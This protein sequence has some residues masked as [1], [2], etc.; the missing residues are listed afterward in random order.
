MP[1]MTREKTELGAVGKFMERNF[2]HYNSRETV[3]AARAYKSHIEGKGK[4]FMAIAGAMS[5]GELGI[6]LAKM[7]REGKIHAISS[8]AANL[9][10][11]LFN[12]MAHDD[13][14]SVPNYRDLTPEQEVALR[15]K[16]F[17]RVTDVCIP[18]DAMRNLE[19]HLV[20]GVLKRAAEK[21]E[22]LFPWE[23]FYRLLDEGE[24][25]KY[26][27]SSEEDSW[28]LAAWEKKLPIYTPGWEDCT[29]A[30]NF[31]ARVIE[32]KVK[33]HNV[34][35]SGLEQ[36]EHLVE[37]YTQNSGK[38]GCGF[39]QIGGGIA[40]DFAICAVPLIIQDLKRKNSP[41]WAYFCQ[42]GDSTT[43]YGSYS[44]AVPN[45]KITWFKISEDT[46]KFMIQ[47]DATLVAP[48]IFSY[49]LGE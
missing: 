39:F 11:D 31:V 26:F 15:D 24:I 4:M 41:L 34:V 38:P 16:G 14:K 33:S 28:V 46:P 17:N 9:E 49:V 1:T 22:R 27:K 10:E 8:T 30:N 45:E 43:S 25:Q 21:G 37:W 2:R 36:M 3:D 32:G 12:L 20:L 5:T 40:G 29:M 35:K 23:A 13:Y 44:G 7:I 6:S 18:E 42:I 48:L 19:K 47:S